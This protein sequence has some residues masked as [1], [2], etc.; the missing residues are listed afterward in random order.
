VLAAAGL[1]RLGLGSRIK[2]FFA[3]EHMLP[4][5]G[6]GALGIEVLESRIDL[7]AL[8]A[9][10]ADTSTWLAVTAERAVSRALGGSCSVA[11][12]AHAHWQGEYLQMHAAWADRPGQV[13]YAQAQALQPGAQQA[14]E[15]GEQLAAQLQAAHA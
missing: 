14:R 2:Q 6:Q 12:A 13:R 4:A 10:L 15:L 7:K 9:P 11:L 1:L 8:L 5:P 3:P